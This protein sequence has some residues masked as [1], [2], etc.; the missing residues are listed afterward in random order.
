MGN[1]IGTLMKFAAAIAT[2]LGMA[3]IVMFAIAAGV[4]VGLALF[5]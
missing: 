4:K 3:V 1:V 5:S 2:L